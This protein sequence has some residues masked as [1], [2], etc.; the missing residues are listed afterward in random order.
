MIIL[1]RRGC[2]ARAHLPIA[3]LGRS[4]SV[5]WRVSPTLVFALVVVAGVLR[6]LVVVVVRAA[7][8]T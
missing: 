8:I 7:L 2:R 3:V 6:A 4:R 5:L 1:D